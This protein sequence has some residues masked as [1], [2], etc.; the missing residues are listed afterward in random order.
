MLETPL[1]QEEAGSDRCP[2][3]DGGDPPTL[4]P[5]TPSLASRITHYD[6]SK[7]ALLKAVHDGAG[8]IRIS[9]P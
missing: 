8:T 5:S 4:G 1:R 7:M 6:M 2:A 3:A 9:A